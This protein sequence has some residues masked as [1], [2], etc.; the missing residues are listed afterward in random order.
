MADKKGSGKKDTGASSANDAFF[1]LIKANEVKYVDFRFTDP[2]GKTQH[3]SYDVRQIDADAIKNGIMIDGSSISGWKEIDESD[4]IIKP[5]VKTAFIDPFTS[6]STVCVVCD[7]IEPETGL[8]YDRDPRSTAKSAEEYLK[9]TGIGD[10]I[11][12]GPE[13]EFFVFDDVRYNTTMN[14]SF[15]RVDSREGAYNSGT[16]YDGGNLAHRPKVK[17]GYFPVQPVDSFNDMRAEM[18][19][20]LEAVGVTPVL[21]HH[22]VAPSQLELGMMFSTLTDMADKVQSYKYVVHNVADLYGKSATFMPKPIA[23][24]NGSGMHCHQ[25]IWKDGKNLFSGDKYADL[26]QECLWYIGGIIKHAKAI[27]AFTNAATNSYKRLVPGYEAPVHLAY[28]SLNRSAS[29]RIPHVHSAKGKRIECRF[30]DPVAN[31]YFAF[32]AMLMAGI[33]GIKNKID[34]GKPEDKNLYALEDAEL[35]HIPRVA[36]SL[37][38]ALEALDKDRGFLKAGGVF[39]DDQ[40]DAYIRL[41]MAEVIEWEATPHPIEFSNYYSS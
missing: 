25:S 34:P 4:M 19:E 5:D 17:G 29:I 2:K 7:V 13:L 41:K 32:A 10:T 18:L 28:S 26:S 21:H 24:D 22:E 14:S 40:I 38:E 23:G 31:P 39:S 1:R 33:D 20:M 36:R 11:Y 12:F 15:Y 8:P 30:P 37:H 35:K 16:D 9:T 6:R 27:N 3:T